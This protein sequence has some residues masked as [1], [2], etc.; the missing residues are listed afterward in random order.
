MPAQ[1]AAQSTNNQG[2]GAPSRGAVYFQAVRAFSFPA[3]MIPC[4]LGAMLA[5]LMGVN[6]SWWLMPFIAISLILLHAASNVTTDYDD[7]NQGVDREETLGGSRVLVQK[8]LKPKEMLTF[9]LTLFALSVIIGIPII[10]ERGYTILILGLAGIMGG[11]FYT[12]KP[13]SFK[14]HALGDVL[15]FLMYGPAIVAGTFYALTGTFVWATIYISI[16]LGLLVVGILQANNLRDILH[17][18]QANIKTL[19]TVFGE[20]FAKGEYI[21]LIAGAYLTV[22]VLVL[23]NI[24]SYWSLLVFLSLPV[25]LKNMNMIKGIKIEDTGKIAMLDALTAQL[26]LMFGILLSISIIITKFVG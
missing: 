12:A 13:F 22:V 17:D 14:Y 10:M 4:L 1:N 24:L 25:A 2:K 16:P 26:T 21:F 23:L 18:R 3:S 15:I 7:F 20:G 9:G 19:A 8:L 11:Y 5:L 6:V